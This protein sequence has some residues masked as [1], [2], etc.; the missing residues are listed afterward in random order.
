MFPGARTVAER[1]GFALV[2]LVVVA[3]GLYQGLQL[4][5]VSFDL[6]GIFVRIVAVDAI[7]A[8]IAF[9]S[10]VLLSG[11][12]LAREVHDDPDPDEQLSEG[13][14]V[15]A[16]VPAYEDAEVLDESVT[17][18]LAS[19]Y[20]DL[21]VCIVVEPDD[22]ATR[23]RAK[24][25]ADR[26][27]VQVLENRHPGSKALAITDAVDRLEADRFVFLDADERVDPDFVP[28]A[29][30]ALVEDGKDAFQARRVPR[31]TGAVEALAYGERLLFHAGHK[32]VEPLG[33]TYCRSSSVAITREAFE[34][35][36]GLDDLLTEDIDLAHKA[37]RADLDVAKSRAVTN[38]MEA[39]HT[40]RDLWGQRRRW[41]TGHIEVLTKALRGGYDRGGWRGLVSTW[42]MGT[43]LAAGLF[44][45]GLAAKVLLL[46]LLDLE[47]LFLV[48]FAAI[49]LALGPVVVRDLRQGHLR[50]LVPAFALIPLI[51]P[52]FGLLTIRSA[53]A[54]VLG[55]DGEWYQVDKTGS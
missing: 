43:S 42:R 2:A 6:F 13:P 22:P 30:H 5:A 19:D 26:D 31:V 36:D 53:F 25:L 24:E 34:A 10:A 3:N 52:G 1:V 9:A 38:E 29:M 8:T 55:W 17:S 7:P 47:L 16:I 15:T 40:L 39:P 18:L 49:T 54:Y 37:F 12:L 27:R 35:V 28:T 21:D 11:I 41:R 51:Y 45:L 50:E 44:L 33:F 46:L 4:E 20:A 48:P 32:L 23:A 14:R